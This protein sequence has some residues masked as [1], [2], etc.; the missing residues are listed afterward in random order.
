MTDT[1]RHCATC[2]VVL[3]LALC[4]SAIVSTAQ[5]PLPLRSRKG[6]PLSDVIKNARKDVPVIVEKDQSPPLNV[7]PPQGTRQLEW[8][9]SLVPLVMVIRIDALDPILRP[10][11]E[12]WVTTT[13]R[14]R[15]EE[16]VKKR[17]EAP[18]SVGDSI[19]FTQDGGDIT[20]NGVRVLARVPW[21]DNFQ[22]G[23]RYLVFADYVGTDVR[24]DPQ[25]SYQVDAQD[26]LRALARQ[27]ISTTETNVSLATALSRIRGAASRGVPVG[28]VADPA[29][30]PPDLATVV[31]RAQLIVDGEVLTV[32]DRSVS[33]SIVAD[34]VLR[35]FE[36]IKDDGRDHG[37]GQITVAVSRV[38]ERRADGSPVRLEPVPWSVGMRLILFLVYSDK[39]AAYG[40]FGGTSFE[41]RNNVVIVP[42]NLSHMSALGGRSSI[43]L[44]ELVALVKRGGR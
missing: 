11:D 40:P 42:S 33:G 44:S 34:L 12:D 18:L 27:G 21:S 7:N 36:V 20:I 15:V 37:T 32:A 17:G 26:A 1:R 3:L 30:P 22:L 29:P 28:S 6:T 38:R 43:P 5:Q 31:Q 39:F 4:L 23:G 41:V 13:V 35:T 8:M 24:V 10:P 19:Q 25:S 9:T 2:L 16:I 14:A